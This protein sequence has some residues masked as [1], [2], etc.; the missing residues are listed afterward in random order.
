METSSKLRDIEPLGTKLR[1]LKE[2]VNEVK[3]DNA[4]K[5]RKDEL[6]GTSPKRNVNEIGMRIQD[7]SRE[8]KSNNPEH[9][10][11]IDA[12]FQVGEQNKKNTLPNF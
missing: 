9:E 10:P 11:M 7:E 8:E 1:Q 5:T 2:P 3:E 12:I 6:Q 4:D